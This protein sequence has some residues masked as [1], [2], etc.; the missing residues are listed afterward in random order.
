M[1]KLY[2]F[3]LRKIINRIFF[4]IIGIMCLHVPKLNYVIIAQLL[5]DMVFLYMLSS[6][7]DEFIRNGNFFILRVDENV[8]QYSTKLF[9][10]N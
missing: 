8:T 1:S 10:N 4:Y 5:Q 3:F 9:I 2:L 7:L 6:I